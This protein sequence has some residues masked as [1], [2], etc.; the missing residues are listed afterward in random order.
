MIGPQRRTEALGLDLD[1][2]A[3][4]L[5][6]WSRRDDDKPQPEVRRSANVAVR[7]IDR[8]LHELHAMRAALVTEIR[9]SDDAAMLDE[10][11]DGAR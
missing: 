6:T 1:I 8:M 3:R 11:R 9:Q 7:C 10:W 5:H 4:E 2:L